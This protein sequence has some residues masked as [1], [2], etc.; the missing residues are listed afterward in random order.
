M[1]SESSSPDDNADAADSPPRRPPHDVSAAQEIGG[2]INNVG[3]STAA[4]PVQEVPRDGTTASTSVSLNDDDP[5]I[6]DRNTETAGLQLHDVPS[7]PPC[8]PPEFDDSIARKV[9]QERALSTQ[10]ASTAF[11]DRL[12]VSHHGERNYLSFT[13]AHRI[14]A[15]KSYR[16]QRATNISPRDGGQHERRRQYCE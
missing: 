15:A 4:P 5:S 7:C 16:F 12:R 8:F 9:D 6:A 13:F 10:A 3:D 11:E 1:A 14:S 2:S